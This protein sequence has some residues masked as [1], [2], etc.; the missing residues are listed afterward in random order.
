MYLAKADE[1][2]LW[3]REQASAKKK[4]KNKEQREACNFLTLFDFLLHHRRKE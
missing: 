2:N 1:Y 3:L 4:K